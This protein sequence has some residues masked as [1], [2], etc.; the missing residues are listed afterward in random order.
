LE[1][2]GTLLWCT[3]TPSSPPVETSCAPTPRIWKLVRSERRVK[4]RLGTDWTRLPAVSMPWA[5]KAC[6]LKAETAIGTS[7]T[8]S[9]RFCAVT[10][11][12][13]ISAPPPED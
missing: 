12:S 13:S 11:S 4:V 5:F 3:P 7:W 10:I 2:S 8:D 1:V 6:S 9:S